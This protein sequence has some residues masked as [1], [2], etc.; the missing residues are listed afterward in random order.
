MAKKKTE[1]TEKSVMLLKFPAMLHSTM[2]KV[3]K[4][5]EKTVSKIYVNAV[6]RYLFGEEIT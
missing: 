2:K 6:E 3:S 4:L 1:K 5:Q